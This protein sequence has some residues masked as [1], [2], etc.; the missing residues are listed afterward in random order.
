[1]RSCNER[2]LKIYS[3]HLVFRR[4]V[5]ILISDQIHFKKTIEFEEKNGIYIY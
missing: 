4:N 2:D 5:A 3:S 1:M